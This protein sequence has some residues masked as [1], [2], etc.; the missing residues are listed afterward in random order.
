MADPMETCPTT[1]IPC[2][3]S[4]NA[5]AASAQSLCT[6]NNIIINNNSS[7]FS[8][9][10]RCNCI[11]RRTCGCATS[12][13]T[14]KTL[15]LRR[16]CTPTPIRRQSWVW[17]CP[18]RQSRMVPSLSRSRTILTKASFWTL[19]CKRD[20]LICLHLCVTS[21]RTMPR[22][23]LILFQM[24]NAS[25]SR[26]KHHPYASDKW[27]L[28]LAITVLSYLLRLIIALWFS[29]RKR[30]RSELWDISAEAM[31]RSIRPGSVRGRLV[32]NRLASTLTSNNSRRNFRK[33]AA[34][35]WVL[36]R[37]R[38]WSKSLLWGTILSRC[39]C[40]TPRAAATSARTHPSTTTLPWLRKE[41]TSQ[42]GVNGGMLTSISRS[43]SAK[44]LYSCRN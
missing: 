29:K 24:R 43:Q 12:S 23:C 21:H 8:I 25:A 26:S 1:T 16:S 39:Q 9:N 10:N 40:T 38:F 37:Q 15:P 30:T 42:A 5:L 20:P 19:W 11:S 36:S 17:P 34:R 28:P 2:R 4:H 44:N 7:N 27:I 22:N 3:Q 6:N 18:R 41:D 14:L 31:T 13:V 32:A 33:I 35:M